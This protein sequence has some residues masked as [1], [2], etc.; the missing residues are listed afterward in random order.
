MNLTDREVRRWLAMW[1]RHDAGCLHD[2][3]ENLPRKR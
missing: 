2:Q 1:A 3:C